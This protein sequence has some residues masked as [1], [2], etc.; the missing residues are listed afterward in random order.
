ME[1]EALQNSIRLILVF[2][3]MRTI[4]ESLNIG[5]ATKHSNRRALEE[6]I[7]EIAHFIIN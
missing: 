7:R 4:C 5:S 3:E 2:H 6:A 1:K